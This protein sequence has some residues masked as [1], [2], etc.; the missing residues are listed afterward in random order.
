V[1]LDGTGGRATLTL[2]ERAAGHTN[3]KG[4]YSGRC[5]HHGFHR[6]SPLRRPVLRVLGS[7]RSRER[8]LRCDAQ[9]IDFVSAKDNPD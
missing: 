2:G 5:K 7:A 4:D 3:T 6:L 8:R 1:P 9:E